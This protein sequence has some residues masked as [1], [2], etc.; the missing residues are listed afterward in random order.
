MRR[1]LFFLLDRLQ[2]T[3]TERMSLGVLAVLLVILGGLNL[4]IEQK[5]IYDEQYYED[6]ER[7]FGE[8]S[9]QA[10]AERYEILARYKPAAEN[11]ASTSVTT[12]LR[13]ET[14]H[15][16][17]VNSDSSATQDQTGVLINI[18]TAGSGMLQQLPGI[19]PAY[20]DRIVEWRELNGVFTS[21]SQLLE[22]RGIGDRRLEAIKP[23]ITL[24]EEVQE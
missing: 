5:A 10:E 1:K 21:K 2:I 9:R 23:L 15:P 14:S 6:L 19:G 7:I 11:E 3:H 13:T 22:I 16:D 17:T 18:N 20:A 24:G 8:R 12:I 4:V